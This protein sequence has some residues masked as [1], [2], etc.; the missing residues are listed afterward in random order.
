MVN[1]SA[2]SEHRSVGT[3][4]PLPSG[5]HCF[6]RRPGSPE[7]QTRGCGGPDDSQGRGSSEKR[8]HQGL[9]L[10]DRRMELKPRKGGAGGEGFSAGYQETKAQRQA[11]KD[12]LRTLL[13]G[14][15]GNVGER[16][17]SSRCLAGPSPAPTFEPSHPP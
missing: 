8:R 14:F 12:V 11:T 15:Q 17:G 10:K 13:G 9:A 2:R 6:L 3:E 7:L 16:R 5:L 1:G 4:V